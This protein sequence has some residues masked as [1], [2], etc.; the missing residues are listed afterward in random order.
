MEDTTMKNKLI[1]LAAGLM[2]MACS[3]DKVPGSSI[4]TEES[5]RNVEDCYKFLNGQYSGMKYFTTGAY[6]YATELQ[7]DLFHAVKNFGNFD[8]DFYHYSVTASNDLAEE[9]WYG[10][11]ANIANINFLIE[12]IQNLK[13]SSSLT[14][15]DAKTLDEYYGEA[16]F[17]RAYYYW[18]LTQYY[19]ETYEAETASTAYGVPVV[20]KYA[21][22]GNSDKYPSRGTLQQTYDQILTDLGDAEQFVTRRGTSLSSEITADAVLALKARIA[23]SMKDYDTARKA[24]EDVIGTGRYTLVSNSSDYAD[25]WINDN[26]SETIFQLAMINSTEVGNAYNYFLYNTSGV[27]GRDNPQYI[28]EDWVLDLY[29]KNRDIRY[30]AYF[31]ERNVSTPVVGRLTLLV[32]YPG[33]PKLYTTVTNY[34][35]MPKVF[36]ASEMY[37]IA[38]EAEHLSSNGTDTKA[39]EYLNAL[40]SARI[41]GWTDHTYSG[42]ALMEEIRNERVKELFCEGFRLGDLKRWHRGFTRSEGQDPTL[43][44]QG[45]NYSTCT[46]PADDPLFLWPIPTSELE[47]NPNMKDEQNS[48]YK[49]D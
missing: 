16:C 21:P 41:S 39:N 40:R 17:F 9:A 23:L 32:K 10:A 42:D 48:G 45:E 12:G 43:V 34:C 29:D 33:N 7:T 20:L 19:C 26:L 28:P 46:R 6:V 44:M 37:L 31:D 38:A 49:M 5:I 36:R 1:L 25:G 3:L 30:A 18:M 2:T 13:N 15:S 4:Y 8:G 35:N 47:A 14:D 24:A 27:E 22:S 11:Y